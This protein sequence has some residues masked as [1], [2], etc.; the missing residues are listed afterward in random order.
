MVASSSTTSTRVMDDVS[1]EHQPMEPSIWSVMSRFSSTAYSMG[2]PLVNWSKKPL[3]MSALASVSV[4][5]GSANRRPALR[6]PANRRLV[7]DIGLL[8]V[9]LN[10]RVG[11]AP[12]LLAVCGPRSAR[13]RRDRGHAW[14]LKE[15][16][17]GSLNPYW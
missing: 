10:G 7:A 17:S 3:T 6:Q 15:Y 11:V 12:A 13:R 8:L 1:I 14:D 5:R 9:D 16:C 4:S 2:S